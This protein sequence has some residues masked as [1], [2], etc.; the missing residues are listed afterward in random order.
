ML[1]N[2][3]V[4]GGQKC[5]TTSLHNYLAAHPQIAMSRDK[6]LDF[7]TS[8]GQRRGL[9]WYEQHFTRDAPVRGE[10][11]PAYTA[12]PHILGVPEAIHE[13]VPDA[14]LIYL[15][16]DPVDR[17]VSEYL[18]A[19]GHGHERRSLIRVAA[20][21]GFEKSPYVA[22]SRYATQLARYLELFD[23]SQLLVLTQEALDHER[24]AT[25]R[26]I[27]AFLGVDESFVS[28][29]FARRYN[30]ARDWRGGA[31]LAQRARDALGEQRFER[32]T[33]RVPRPAQRIGDRMMR[34]RIATPELPAELR[35]RFVS[36]LADDTA[37]LTALTGLDLSHWSTARVNT[38]APAFSR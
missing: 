24:L 21:P 35:R 29:R 9:A 27:F 3:I 37:R 28:P 15:V 12:W 36:L 6:E 14:R 2:L 16:R 8:W 11:S 26:Q 25:L 34:R 10:S 19:V 22:K 1:P 38:G 33:G 23:S 30:K 4:I 32:L 7:F 31:A 17:I 5:G 18:H 13:T 20:Q